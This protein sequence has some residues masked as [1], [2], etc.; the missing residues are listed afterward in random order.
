MRF[1]QKLKEIC[2]IP[3]DK[4]DIQEDEGPITVS[5]FNSIPY[6]NHNRLV[7]VLYFIHFA[8]SKSFLPLKISFFVASLEALTTTDKTEVSHKVTERVV[9]LLGGELATKKQNFKLIKDAYAIRSSY[10][11]GSKLDKK[12]Q[13]RLVEISNEIDALL[14]RLLVLVLDG[15]INIF[16][17]D[18]EKLRDWFTDLILENK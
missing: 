4:L 11:H 1:Y 5:I 16:M 9:L 17:M 12:M 2:S 3:Y 10:L 18:E 14:R 6:N 13:P 8:R 15:M 7:R